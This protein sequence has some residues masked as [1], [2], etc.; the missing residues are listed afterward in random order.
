MNIENGT[1]TLEDGELAPFIPT[2]GYIVELA[3]FNVIVE[4]KPLCI[5]LVKSLFSRYPLLALKANYNMAVWNNPNKSMSLNL[6]IHTEDYDQ[7]LKIC[8]LVKK[9][10]FWGADRFTTYK[11]KDASYQATYNHAGV[12][13]RG[14]SS[15]SVNDALKQAKGHASRKLQMLIA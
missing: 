10:V 2:E 4:L 3:D 11:V 13:Y 5:E 12:S 6:S 7:A 14:F 9:E 8:H 15:L 1:Y